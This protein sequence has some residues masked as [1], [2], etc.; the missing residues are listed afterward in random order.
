MKKK[1]CD[2]QTDK[3]IRR[4]APLL[5]ITGELKNIFIS[6]TGI[7]VVSVDGVL[8]H[9]VQCEGSP[10]PPSP[11][12]HM[13]HNVTAPLDDSSLFYYLYSRMGML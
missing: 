3:V 1:I 5:K 9:A 7:A 13:F 11:L 4:E 2:R 6:R 10:A 12:L 8:V